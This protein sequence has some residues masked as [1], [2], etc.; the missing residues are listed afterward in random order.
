MALEL[1]RAASQLIGGAAWTTYVPTFTGFSVNPVVTA[2]YTQLGKIVHVNIVCNVAGTS[3][4]TTTTVTLPVVSTALHS[5]IC[6]SQT[7]DN[8]VPGLSGM[9]ATS[10]GTNVCNVHKTS[11]GGTT[12]WTASSLKA[13]HFNLTYE[14]A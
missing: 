7:Y 9:A 14:A 13:F 1:L 5:S 2:Y 3:N 10:P 11:D 6:W 4:A 12:G 8:G